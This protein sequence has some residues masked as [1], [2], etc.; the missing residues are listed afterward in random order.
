M[1]RLGRGTVASAENSTNHE[2]LVTNGIGG[3]ASGTLSGVL[4]RRYHGLL[5]AAL[6]PP[7]GRTL[8]VS[9]L[10]E[11]ATYDTQ[12]YPLF[13][14][15]WSAGSYF[16]DGH[17]LIDSFHLDGTS[18]VWRYAVGDALL[19]KRL[20][21]QQGANTTYVT[22]TLLRGRA[23]LTLSAKVIVNYRDYHGSTSAGDWEMEIDGTP[24]GL[25]IQARDDAA[26]YY[27]LSANGRLR[28]HHAWYR[29][30]H[31]AVEAYRGQPEREDHLLAAE[32]MTTLEAGES[33]TLVLSAEPAPILDGETAWASQK[34]H[35]RRILESTTI[36]NVAQESA[37]STSPS[38]SSSSVSQQA[39]TERL[40]HLLLAADQFIVARAT[41]ADPDGRTII[42][43]YP[44]FG[45]W[46]RDTMIAL[47]GLTL[48]TGRFG[49]AA[50]ILR[51][52]ARFVDRGMLPNRFPDDNE[53]PEYNTVD[54]TLWYF[55]AIRAYHA[56]TGDFEL[57]RELFPVLQSIITAHREG[58]RYR[59]KQDPAD[60]LIYSGE[61]GVQLTWMDAKVDGWVV[62][63]RTGKAVEINALWYN[64]LCIMDDFARLLGE[65]AATYRNMA[66][67]VRQGFAKFWNEEAG[68][69]Y[70]VIGGP[71]F[72]VADL[73]PNQL[74][75][76][77]LKYSPL[78]AER[79]KQVV[80]ACARHLLTP[81]GLRSLG[82][83]EVDYVGVYGGD[84]YTRDGSY[85]QGTT[86]GWLIGP[87]VSAHL[88]VYD[89]PQQAISFLSPLINHLEEACVGSM[90]EIFDGN[91]PYT[92]RGAFA[93]A[94]T[95]AE[96]L[97]T[98]KLTQDAAISQQQAAKTQDKSMS[99]NSQST[100]S[101]LELQS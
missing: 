60:G 18:P 44:W 96:V 4:T 49:I 66:A 48:A 14:N 64:A 87:F 39:E 90:S 31:L 37:E 53:E 5:V 57:V 69:C 97:R 26:P 24:N 74:F 8:L 36:A 43:G 20:W 46:G 7:L 71:N 98:W 93:Q 25:R 22:Y 41:D 19:E 2:W 28:R 73:R 79:Q 62:T 42:A 15:S 50:K 75:A 99:E 77:S 83:D 32:F 67:K 76:V 95:V 68:F 86:W 3:F 54:A 29:N 17:K 100:L 51:T 70:D 84:R 11:T 33:A 27:L 13:T 94:W 61:E 10:D 30:Y 1:F 59:I 65:N 16:T 12:S 72:S 85:H 45:D 38:P 92:A 34:A 56:A 23:P 91:A 63:P 88:R 78:S 6:Q 89:N 82:P 80:D 52:F 40:N 81:H 55:E 101:L 35:E 47:P 21:M 58:T 9:K